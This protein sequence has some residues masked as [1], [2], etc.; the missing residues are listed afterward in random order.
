MSETLSL[1]DARKLLLLS[2][3]LP[4][5]KP[6]GRALSA[7][8]AAVRHL[9]YIQIDTLSVVERAHHHTLWNRSRR[10]QP[11]HL[12]LLLQGKNIF[13]YWSH[14]AAYLPTE[15]Y[16]F[17]LPRMRAFAD[18]ERHWFARDHKMMN[19]VLQRITVDGPLRARDFAPESKSARRVAAKMWDRKPAKRALEQLF[20]E[21][22]LMTLR[23][24]GFNKVYDLTE[25]VLAPE[26]DTRMPSEREYG[27]FLVRRYLQANGLGRAAEIVYLRGAL[28]PMVENC[29]TRMARRGEIVPLKVKDR[30]YYALPDSLELLGKPLS[31]KRL[32]ILSPFDNLLIQRERMR[33]LF[34]FDYQIECY[35]PAT[36]R[37]HGYFSLPLL[38]D[39]KLVAR[40]DCK[41]E[42]Q[43]R[44]LVI[45]NLVSEPTLCKKE[46]LAKALAD[47]LNYFATF[48]RC[49]RVE[50]GKLQDKT[51]QGWLSAALVQKSTGG[52]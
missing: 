4:W 15:D 10:Y 13:E 2:Q 3:W 36:K 49:E 12:E 9:G 26:V 19:K 34:G 1:S 47:E 28:K 35:T 20:M 52:F 29:I 42:R 39:G 37:K 32:K 50:V 43:R 23:R 41:A 40:M 21:G 8:L 30:I 48:N 24:Q 17:C 27:N 45:R 44:V 18:G 5:V 6:T 25:R 16:R 33:H 38:W 7:T 14:A 46:S 11:R 31:R 51:V 22:Q